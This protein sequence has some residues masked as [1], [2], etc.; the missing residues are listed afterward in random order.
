MKKE[1]PKKRMWQWDNKE[2]RVLEGEYRGVFR[3]V[4][5]MYRV[6]RQQSEV[7]RG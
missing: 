2:H 3:G 6:T 1:Q 7:R 5:K 4:G